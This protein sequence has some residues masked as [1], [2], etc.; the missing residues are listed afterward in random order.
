MKHQ[1]DDLRGNRGRSSGSPPI[2]IV[3]VPGDQLAMPPENRIRS[4]D[5]GQLLEPFPPEDLTFDSQPPAL[6]VVEQDSLL[7]ELLFEDSILGQEA[8]DSVLLSAI[9]PSGKDQK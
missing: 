2:A 1:L 6:V 3:P 9:D 8:L 7:S 4:D 5:G